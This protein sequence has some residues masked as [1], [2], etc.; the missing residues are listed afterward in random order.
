MSFLCAAAATANAD[1]Q[2]EPYTS[3]EVLPP[4]QAIK[5]SPAAAAAADRGG[6][7]NCVRGFPALF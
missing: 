4:G 6:G 1:V 5:V 3:L 2:D 7:G